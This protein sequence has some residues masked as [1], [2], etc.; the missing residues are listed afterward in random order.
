[1]FFPEISSS[2]DVQSDWRCSKC[3]RKRKNSGEFGQYIER[4]GGV[5][6]EGDVGGV[7]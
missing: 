5:S 7:V 2:T 6:K 3:K 1:M 4:C